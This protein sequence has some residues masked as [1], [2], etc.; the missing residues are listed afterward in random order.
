MTRGELQVFFDRRI[1][2]WRRLDV[3]TL[4]QAHAEDGVLESPIAGRVV[5]HSAIENVYRG[6][7]SAFPDMNVESPELVIE[8][9]R[10]VQ[11]VTFSGTNSHG[12]MGVPP[13]GKKFMFPAALI[14]TM[15]ADR[16]VHERR[17][18]D[19]AGFLMEIG[20][21]KVKLA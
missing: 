21:I 7:M 14:C 19:F 6:F 9:D 3:E 15:R 11:V 17:I 13:T 16:I 5:G 8:G 2:A 12:F 4:V 18:Y 20:V 10:V 1:E